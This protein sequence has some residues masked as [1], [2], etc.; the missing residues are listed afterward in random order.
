MKKGYSE[1][2]NAGFTLVELIAVIAIMLVLVGTAVL[3]FRG[4]AGQRLSQ[5][6]SYTDSML[7]E[8][9]QNA[10]AKAGQYA[11]FYYD[12]DQDAYYVQNASGY[13]RRLGS[14]DLSFTYETSDG[15]TFDLK[16]NAFY[17]SYDSANGSALPV[18]AS[19]G[20]DGA[21]NYA[22]DAAGNPYYLKKI[23]I[24]LDTRS[25]VITLYPKTGR[26]VVEET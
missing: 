15:Q 12:T 7:T 16:D 19:I 1:K 22:A 21:Y 6:V 18:I 23:T 4:S 13:E 25:K 8:T 11:Y 3:S 24:S 20:S 10:M 26:H 2:K 5:A 14:E 17:I 9:Q